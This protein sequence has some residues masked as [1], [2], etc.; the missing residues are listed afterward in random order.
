MEDKDRIQNNV[1]A[2]QPPRVLN[3]PIEPLKSGAL[4]PRWR[5][6]QKIGV[7]I[8]GCPD[9]DDGKLQNIFEFVNENLLTRTPE[10]DKDDSCSR[11]ADPLDELVFFR[12][13]QRSEFGRFGTRDMKRWIF[14]EQL[15]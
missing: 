4:N 12:F 11:F 2:P 5:L 10:S 13:C 14:F 9:S 8:E 15:R 3:Q 1:T 6:P 7:I